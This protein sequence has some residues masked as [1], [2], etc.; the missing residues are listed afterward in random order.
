MS[1]RS[2]I[3]MSRIS[4]ARSMDAPGVSDLEPPP[5]D[6]LAINLTQ[7]VVADR[8]EGQAPPGEQLVTVFIPFGA[9]EVMAQYRTRGPRLVGQAKRQ[10]GFDQPVQRL[11]RMGGGLA[12]LDDHTEPVDRGSEMIAAQVVSPDF[13]FL[14]GQMV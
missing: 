11:G 5:E 6:H 1:S 7:P 8:L 9:A 12:I 13:H 14:G 10:L 3:R 4:S 2:M